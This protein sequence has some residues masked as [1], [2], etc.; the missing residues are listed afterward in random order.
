MLFFYRFSYHSGMVVDKNNLLLK[1]NNIVNFEHID[2]VL[3]S[4]LLTS[5]LVLV[6]L[7]LNL[8]M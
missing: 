2:V 1:V 8:N 6:F 5:D 3:V 7:L 4:L